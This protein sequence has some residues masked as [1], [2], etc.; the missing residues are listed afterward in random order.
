MTRRKLPGWPRGLVIAAVRVGIASVVGFGISLAASSIKPRP[1]VAGEVRDDLASG[2]WVGGAPRPTVAA[3]LCAAP[4]I[5]RPAVADADEL[6]AR[7]DC[8]AALGLYLQARQADT[9]VESRRRITAQIVWCYQGLEQWS[10]A[11]EEFLLL[12]RSDPN[13]PYFGCIPL[14][15]TPSQPALPLEQSARQWLDRTDVPAAQLQGA[16]HLLS[17]NSSS[18][19][20]ARLKSLALSNDRRIAVL[21]TAQIWRNQ[22]VTA[23]AEQLQGW[24]KVVDGMPEELR[25]GPHFVLGMAWARQK[26]WDR[27]ALALLRVPIV[28][29]EHR[30]M[31]ARALLE[32]GQALE[33]LKRSEQAATLYR[34]LLEKY[35][36][37]SSALEARPRLEQLSRPQ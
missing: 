3:L 4:S 1:V 19:A 15:W 10:E 5:K 8:R 37:S 20:L 12:L 28:Y 22:A 32:A 16:S 2:K 34:E 36:D 18:A 30:A 35:P 27:A 7:G 33:H 24:Q 13:T 17:T 29:P 25:A 26:D 9:R 21:A 6:L 14:A 11:G 23:T 31:S